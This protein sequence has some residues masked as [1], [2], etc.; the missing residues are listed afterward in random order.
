[1]PLSPQKLSIQAVNSIAID[2][3]L[4]DTVDEAMNIT[5]QVQTAEVQINGNII[6][7]QNKNVP[8]EVW[9]S[10]F[11]CADYNVCIK[12]NGSDFSYIQFINLQIYKGL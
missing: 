2:K 11:H 8:D 6:G 7:D 9:Q 4:P 10:R 3:I 1:M 12:Q 5:E